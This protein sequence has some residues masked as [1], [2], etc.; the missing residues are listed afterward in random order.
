M[1]VPEMWCLSGR[2][3]FSGERLKVGRAMLDRR[4]APEAQVLAYPDGAPHS[5]CV[6][7]LA[8]VRRAAET[9]NLAATPRAS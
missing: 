9:Y 3:P 8:E 5:R 2:A 7:F 6:H 1:S 4:E